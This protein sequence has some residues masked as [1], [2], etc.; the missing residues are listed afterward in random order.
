MKEVVAVAPVESEI[1][2]RLRLKKENIAKLQR[3]QEEEKQRVLK[4]QEELA[5][6][7]ELELLEIE[8][9]YLSVFVIVCA[10]FVN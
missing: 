5:Q 9:I 3:E 4:E 10:R 2:K 6:L 1:A 8:V 7:A